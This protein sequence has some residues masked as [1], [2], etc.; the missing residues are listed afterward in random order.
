MGRKIDA[1][2]DLYA[3]GI[4]LYEGATGRRPI[5]GDSLYALIRNHVEHIPA[6]PRPLRPDLPEAYEAAI[7][8]ALAK[9]PNA[10]FGSAMA[11]D[12]A[13]G[14]T[15]LFGGLLA[16]RTPLDDT[17]EWDGTD[18]VQRWGMPGGGTH[19]PHL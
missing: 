2:A 13:R 5:P 14:R 12:E 4:I 15:V 8:R 3:L 18:W 7:L 16:D 17:W 9:D 6:A 1:R 11:F 19:R 10:R